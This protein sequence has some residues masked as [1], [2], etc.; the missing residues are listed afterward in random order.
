MFFFSGCDNIYHQAILPCLLRPELPPF[1]YSTE[2]YYNIEYK[3]K[4]RLVDENAYGQNKH[5]RSLESSRC[6]Y[7][8]TKSSFIIYKMNNIHGYSVIHIFTH[9][10]RRV[11]Y[12][13]MPRPCPSSSRLLSPFFKFHNFFIMEKWPVSEQFLVKVETLKKIRFHMVKLLKFQS[14]NFDLKLLWNWAFFHY[15]KIMRYIKSFQ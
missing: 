3:K 8:F 13:M 2:R 9:P 4:W 5:P 14:F 11:T 10:S 7:C 15:E 6:V 12:I 1:S